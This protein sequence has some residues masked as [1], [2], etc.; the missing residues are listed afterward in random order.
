LVSRQTS[1]ATTSPFTATA[2]RVSAEPPYVT[3]WT[4]WPSRLRIAAPTSINRFDV[5]ASIVWLHEICC[6]PAASVRLAEVAETCTPGGS[7]QPLDV[8]QRQAVGCV[9]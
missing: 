3:L 2:A 6:A 9:L 5:P 4:C 7:G 8:N 1:A